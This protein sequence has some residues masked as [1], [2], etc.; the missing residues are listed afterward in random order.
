MLGHSLTRTRGSDCDPTW[1][2]LQ[3]TLVM[4]LPTAET[5]CGFG[6]DTH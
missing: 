4:V 3:P 6:R 2:T 1:V 5:C